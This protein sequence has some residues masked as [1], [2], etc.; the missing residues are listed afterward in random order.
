MILGDMRRKELALSRIKRLSSSSL[1]HE[2]HDVR[3]CSERRQR[4]YTEC[5]L[6]LRTVVRHRAKY[7]RRRN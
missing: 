3:A 4:N 1:A 5:L 6:W 2:P 7:G